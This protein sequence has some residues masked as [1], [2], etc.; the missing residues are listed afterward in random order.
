MAIGA[1]GEIPTQI[2]NEVQLRAALFAAK[3]ADAGLDARLTAAEGDIDAIEADYVSAASVFAVDETL[4]VSDGT[5]RGAKAGAYTE[6][7]LGTLGIGTFSA[8]NNSGSVI[9]PAAAVYVDGSG[10]VVAAQ[11]DALATSEVSGL[12]S[13]ELIDTET[14]DILAM[15]VVS[16]VTTDWDAVTGGSGGLTP[17]SVYYLSPATAGH[18][19][20]TAPTTATQTVVPV[21]FALT[22]QTAIIIKSRPILL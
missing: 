19:T 21:L 2:H 11:A 7:F 20:L 12:A 4:L 8:T 13:E 14:A 5:V 22:A 16:F 17:G 1:S 9:P 18:L 6:A 3:Q 10:D 15:G